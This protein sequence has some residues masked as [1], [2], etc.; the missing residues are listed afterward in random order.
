MRVADLSR[1]WIVIEVPEAQS[2]GLREGQ[3][4][5]ARV[6]A[7]L[8]QVLKGKVDYVYPNLD[9]Q[10]RTVRARMS[11]DNPQMMLK[12]GMYAEVSLAGAAQKDGLRVP[13][14]AV[15]RTGTRNV[16]ILALGQGRF[17]PAVVQVGEDRNGWTEI[18]SGLDEGETVVVSGQFL[19]DSE[20]SLRGSLARM[21]D[22][23][24]TP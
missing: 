13:S 5:E 4:V 15:I 2:A 10:A 19:I 12:P 9:V 17:Q 14:E 21:A 16:V 3:M 8:G 18:V 23:E 6:S 22:A 11:F 7:M 1:V 24:A 20:A